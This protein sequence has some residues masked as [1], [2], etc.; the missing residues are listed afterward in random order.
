MT[1]DAL[2]VGGR[3]HR[4]SVWS[5]TLGV[6][7]VTTC[8]QSTSKLSSTVYGLG[9]NAAGV[10]ASPGASERV[11]VGCGC[12]ARA[13]PRRPYCPQLVAARSMKVFALPLTAVAVACGRQ[14]AS[15]LLQLNAAPAVR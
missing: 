11:G 1:R 13:V 15:W 6:T 7:D 12:Q 4:H 5:L 14:S 3:R 9:R 2:R 10:H 8:L